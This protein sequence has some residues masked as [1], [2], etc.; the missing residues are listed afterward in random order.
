MKSGVSYNIDVE[1]KQ[2]DGTKKL[3][4]SQ[5]SQKV[6]NA[7]NALLLAKQLSKNKNY[8]HSK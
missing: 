7:Y 8:D 5:S 4:P 6:V 3:L 1:I 2:K